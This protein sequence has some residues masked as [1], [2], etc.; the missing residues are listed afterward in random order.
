MYN[1]N[2][3]I[4]VR[5]GSGLQCEVLYPCPDGIQHLLP[6]ARLPGLARLAATERF[7]HI[8]AKTGEAG[9]AL[10][11]GQPGVLR[12]AIHLPH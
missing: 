4:D 8:G 9:A 1:L 10:Q 5:P 3:Y 11:V 6:Q 2:K 7:V 12:P